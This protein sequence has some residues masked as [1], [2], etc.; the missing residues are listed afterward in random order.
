MSDALFWPDVVA[1][2]QKRRGRLH[3]YESLDAR[4]TALIVIDMQAAFVDPG[5]PSFVPAARAIVPNVNRLAA[6]VRRAGGNVAWSRASFTSERDGGGSTFFGYAVSEAVADTVIATLR[7]G[8]AGHGIAAG[9][10]VKPADHVFDKYRFSCFTRGSSEIEAWL[11]Q[12][13]VDTVLIAGTLTHVCC[14]SSARDAMQLGF[15]TVM[16]SDANAS[17]VETNHV[18]TL[19]A[20]IQSFGDVRNVDETIALLDASASAKA[21]E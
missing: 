20:F 11:R 1:L 21:A 7:P 16:V 9:L 5:T 17:R 3:A 15:K 19:N 2:L 10:D 13:S 18:A 4:R 6:A 12:H 8:A 14:E